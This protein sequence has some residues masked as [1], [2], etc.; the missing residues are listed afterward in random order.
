MMAILSVVGRTAAADELVISFLSNEKGDYDIFVVD[1]AGT[2][3]ERI[4]TDPLQKSGLTWSPDPNVF[5]FSSGADGNLDVFKMDLRDREPIR[6]T[7]HDERDLRPTWSPNGKW[8]A[9]ISDRNGKHDVFR[10]DADGA[11]LIQ[12]TNEG[13]CG[14]PTWSPD[15]QWIAVDIDHDLL[16]AIFVMNAEGDEMRQV[17]GDLPLFGGCSW[18]PDGERIAFSAG[19]FGVEPINVF[20]VDV[21]GE[22]K[23]RLTNL[24]MGLRA[25]HPAW[26]PDGEWIAYSVG[27][28]FGGDNTIYVIR[29]DGVGIGKPLKETEGLSVRHVPVWRYGS[30]FWASPEI[31]SRWVTWGALKESL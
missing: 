9:F 20:T 25:I 1:M 2:V 31:G 8:I 11:N 18:S 4:E 13:H 21:N 27:P 16:N 7:F 5:G 30:F 17:T 22:D 12:L 14:L 24:G 28:M 23:K 26:S 19:R 29:S 15:S 3:L 10:I 6:L